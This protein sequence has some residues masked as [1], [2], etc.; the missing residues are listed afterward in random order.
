NTGEGI[1]QSYQAKAT[2]SLNANAYF[3]YNFKFGKDWQHYISLNTRMY[4][5]ENYQTIND[6]EN[7]SNMT[8][9]FVGQELSV[10]WK[11]LIGIAP[12]YSLNIQN[13]NNSVKDNSDFAQR[14]Y[15]SHD[16]GVGLNINPI[17]EFSLESVYTLQ[18]RPNGINSRANFNILN[19]SLYYTMKNNSQLKISAFDILNQNVQN[20]W[21][22]QGNSEYY[23]NTVTLRQY[24]LLGYV[25][26]FN[27]VKTK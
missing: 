1:L 10:R 26:K 19:A 4:N 5:Y 14:K 24:F 18:N 21:G 2:K 13:S 6:I 7:K 3:R 8:Q 22:M 15:L 27:L 11:N 25:H 12:K 23:M 20:F 9:W 16:Y 17:K